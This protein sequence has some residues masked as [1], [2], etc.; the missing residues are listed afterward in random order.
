MVPSVGE[1]DYNARARYYGT[2]LTQ[3]IRIGRPTLLSNDYLQ[4]CDSSYIMKTY[5]VNCERLVLLPRFYAMG[6]LS[7]TGDGFQSGYRLLSV[8]RNGPWV[9]KSLCRRAKKSRGFAAILASSSDIGMYVT[10]SFFPVFSSYALNTSLND[11]GWI[12]HQSDSTS[13]SECQSWTLPYYPQR[14]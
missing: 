7:Y 6:R 10:S 11:Y 2:G 1:S 4:V 8:R 9:A 12:C 5:C 13:E 14:W 3:Y